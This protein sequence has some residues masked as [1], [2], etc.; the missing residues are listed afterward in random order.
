ML[1]LN[2]GSGGIPIDGYVSIDRKE[3][4]EAYPLEYEDESVDVVRASHVLEHFGHRDIE[5]VLAEWTRVLKPGGILKIAVPDFRS[6]AHQY[7]AG[8]PDNLPLHCYIMGGQVD[9]DDSHG[10]IFDEKTLR[11]AMRRAGIR[12]I[13]RWESEI[14][15][16]AALPI[17]LNL[18]GVKK[19]P[20]PCDQ[21]CAM[22]S[23]PR[24]GPLAT[25]MIA[26]T[27][28]PELKIKILP[29][30]GAFWRKSMTTAFNK[31]IRAGFKYGLAVDYDTIFDSAS[32]EDLHYLM[33]TSDADA[34]CAVQMQR[35][36]PKVLSC[37]MGADG[38]YLP[39][40]TT[41]TFIPEL[42]P[43]VAGHFGLT[44]FRLESMAKVETPWFIA[45][46]DARGG[47]DTD[48]GATD[49]DMVFWKKFVAGAGLKLYQ[50]NHVAVGHAQEMFTWPDA[51]F[52]SIH[53]YANDFYATGKPVNARD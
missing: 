36:G 48:A 32:V 53:Q 2:L 39:K 50:A 26:M 35:G 45:E 42:T 40:A 16:C 19:V 22:F 37:P 9:E 3:G 10:A 47:W 13:R 11:A 4:K 24:F 29:E 33:E 43:L 5:T 25:F 31:A 18:E 8:N 6:A 51:G 21:T 38:K 15:D 14:V 27:V 28:L 34:I 12:H 17:S 20:A 30:G 52:H 49:E 1:R 7:L 23:I 41:A 44:L 46:P